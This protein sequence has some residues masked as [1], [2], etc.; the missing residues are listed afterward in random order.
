MGA[1]SFKRDLLHKVHCENIGP[2]LSQALLSNTVEITRAWINLQYTY[3][4]ELISKSDPASFGPPE[5]SFF[6]A[7]TLAVVDNKYATNT[8]LYNFPPRR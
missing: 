3:L 2:K 6:I 7:K 4:V 8:R 5:M 1:S